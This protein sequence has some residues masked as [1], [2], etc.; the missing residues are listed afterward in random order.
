[1]LITV[2]PPT[3]TITATPSQVTT[4]GGN[5]TLTC[6]IQL[7]QS[8]DSNVTVNSTWIGPNS[9][10]SSSILARPYQSTLMLGSLAT[11]GAGNY[12]CSVLVSPVN[13]AFIYQTIQ[14]TTILGKVADIFE[15]PLP[16]SYSY[17]QRLALYFHLSFSAHNKHH[18]F[19]QSS[20]R[21]DVRTY[22]QWC[23]SRKLFTDPCDNMEECNW[24]G[25]QWKWHH[26]IQWCP[27]I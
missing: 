27:H 13:N 23:S 2:P 17:L 1:M 24:S 18:L 10:T 11:T 19:R 7:G 12:T 20:G 25:Y 16:T 9:L 14:R 8:V 15:A 26:C 5:I 3:V 22:L 4:V 6:N 21:T